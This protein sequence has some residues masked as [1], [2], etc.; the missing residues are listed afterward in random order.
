MRMPIKREPKHLH[1]PASLALQLQELSEPRREIIRPVL[2]SPCEFVLLNF[3][4]M[5]RRLETGPA[6]VVRIVQALGFDSYKDFQHYL[7]YLSLSS[8]TGEG[9]PHLGREAERTERSGRLHER[10]R[11]PRRGFLSRWGD[12]ARKIGETPCVARSVHSP[13]RGLA[14]FFVRVSAQELRG[15]ALR[16]GTGPQR[17]VAEDASVCGQGRNFLLQ[18]PTI[19]CEKPMS[20]TSTQ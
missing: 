17:W 12:E 7:H 20:R 2:E 18:S 4:D 15:W 1:F 14:S 9:S 16:A 19:S 13:L 3:R 10:H 8:A 5:A 11:G 6:T